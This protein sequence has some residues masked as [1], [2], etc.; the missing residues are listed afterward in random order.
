MDVSAQT[1]MKGAAK[2]DK[3]CKLQNSVSQQIPECVPCSRD[4][5]AS[6]LSSV[7]YTLLALYTYSSFFWG[8]GVWEAFL[9]IKNSPGGF[10]MA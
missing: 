2:C 7:S 8:E 3:H 9:V 4:T 1:M 10:L 6:V 5:P